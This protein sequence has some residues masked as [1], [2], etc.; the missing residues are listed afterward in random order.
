MMWYVAGIIG[1]IILFII[2]MIKFNTKQNINSVKQYFFIEV[3]AKHIVY[4]LVSM[5]CGPATLIYG[6]VKAIRYI[7]E[8][9]EIFDDVLIEWKKEI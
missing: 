4:F 2:E 5:F 7:C 9:V 6:F 3:K 1:G 8:N